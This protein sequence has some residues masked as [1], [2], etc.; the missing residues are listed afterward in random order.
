MIHVLCRE[1]RVPT[2]A[3]TRWRRSTTYD[4][5]RGTG[6]GVDS[7]SEFE[8][9]TAAVLVVAHSSFLAQVHASLNSS[10]NPLSPARADRATSSHFIVDC[11]HHNAMVC[12]CV[13]V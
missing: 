8:S 1:E 11:V 12:V 9:E 6:G 4:S 7:S 10:S 2:S 13:C 5:L 3:L